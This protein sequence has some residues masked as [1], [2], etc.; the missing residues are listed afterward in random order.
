MRLPVNPGEKYA[1]VALN[2]GTT[3]TVPVDL[4][5]GYYALPGGDLELP[6]RWRKWI[7]SI[8][9]EA[10]ENAGL[11]I[12]VKRPARVPDVIDADDEMLRRQANSLYWGLL[13]SGHVRISD[14]GTLLGGTN[15]E[16]GLTVKRVGEV[17]RVNPVPGTLP[18]EITPAHLALA[19]SLASNLAALFATP[20]MLRMRL[21][22][23][24]FM[25]A[26]SG[27]DLGERI[28]QFV[29]SVDGLTRVRRRHQFQSRCA[30]FVGQAGTRTCLE[31]YA[32]RSNVE[33]FQDP[34]A[35]TD[36]RPLPPRDNWIRRFR[37]AHEAE[38][39]AR[40]CLSHLVSNANL[41]PHFTD[42]QV[43]AFWARPEDE[44]A[45]IW[46]PQIDVAAAMAGFN[47]DA[48]PEAGG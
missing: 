29:R 32:I 18:D 30:T 37:R 20:G 36:I 13:A 16:A 45:A 31:L 14:A 39:L 42:D 5:N 43:S 33:H 11:I 10:V 27:R 7:G 15:G 34:E 1:L 35:D 26:F 21:A 12:L 41:W 47:P 4:G 28:H 2:A 8:K 3:I 46:G 9:A 25:R 19:A 38:I 40:Y 44:R 6:A 22:M 23:G 48:L 17:E 24:T